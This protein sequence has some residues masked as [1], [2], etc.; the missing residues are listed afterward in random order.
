MRAVTMPNAKNYDEMLTTH[1][2]KRRDCPRFL[3][4]ANLITLRCKSIAIVVFLV[5]TNLLTPH[6]KSN[7][8]VTD[9]KCVQICSLYIAKTTL[10]SRISNV[11]RFDHSTLQK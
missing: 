10:L 6:C 3:V 7:A 4:C 5:W 8:I 9:F 1:C 2:R 11:Y